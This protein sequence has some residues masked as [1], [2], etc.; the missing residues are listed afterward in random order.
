M[1][2]ISD[3]L[4]EFIDDEDLYPRQIAGLRRIA[5]CIDAEMV[6]LPKDKD[7]VPIHV[8]DTVYLD[9]GRKAEVTHIDLVWGTSCI[10]CWASGKDCD[11]LPSGI[12][13]TVPDSWE[14]IADDLYE[15]ADAAGQAD[16][17]CEMLSNFA[18][19]I[20]KLAKKEGQK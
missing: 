5:D 15:V 3:E 11:C 20:L 19:R 10:V 2:K 18:H 8:R 6:E 16:D 13:H 12:S 17:M 14:R 9:D 7:G 4:R 1:A